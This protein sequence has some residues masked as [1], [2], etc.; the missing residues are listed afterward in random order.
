MRV[1][2]HLGAVQILRQHEFRQVFR[3]SLP[4]HGDVIFEWPLTNKFH[5]INLTMNK[6]FVEDKAGVEWKIKIK[7]STLRLGELYYIFYL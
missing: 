6:N 2:K 7:I 1:K 5:F 3:D 4:Q